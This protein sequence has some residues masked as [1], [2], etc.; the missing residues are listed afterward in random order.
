MRFLTNLTGATLRLPRIKRDFR[1]TSMLSSESLPAAA[2]TS[3]HLTAQ[4]HSLMF[5]DAT[6]I[7]NGAVPLHS[8]LAWSFAKRL[9]VL[10]GRHEATPPAS[11]NN[12]SLA[13]YPQA[14]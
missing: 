5:Y 1:P 8:R 11:L 6:R 10:A 3:A 13:R 4:C 2:L 12:A 7:P 14:R 9:A